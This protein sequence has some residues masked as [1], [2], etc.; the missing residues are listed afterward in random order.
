MK[1]LLS[2]ISFLFS[3]QLLAATC[4]WAMSEVKTQL[5]VEE[6]ITTL[7]DLH[8]VLATREDFPSYYG[9]NLDALYDVIVNELP[10][11]VIFKITHLKS[12]SKVEQRKLRALFKD[13]KTELGDE[14]CL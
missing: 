1:I 12:L 13:L 7:A 2:L 6:K 9:Q 8:E 10:R 14:L 4:P 5:V 3:T 11:P